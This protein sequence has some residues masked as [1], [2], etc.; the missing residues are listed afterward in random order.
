MGL[1]TYLL[2]LV[3]ATVNVWRLIGDKSLNLVR[4]EQSSYLPHDMMFKMTLVYCYQYT[5]VLI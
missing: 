1:F 2:L 5:S 3:L 4:Y